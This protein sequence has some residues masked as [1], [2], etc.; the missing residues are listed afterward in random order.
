VISRLWKAVTI[1]YLLAISVVAGTGYCLWHLLNFGYFPPPM[2]YDISDTWMDWFNTAYYAVTGGAYES[3]KSIYPPVSFV[4]LRLTNLSGC[5]LGQEA[6]VARRCDWLGIGILHGFYILNIALVALTYIK[7]DRRTALPRAIALTT[8]LAMLNGLDRGNLVIVCFSF[9]VLAFGPLLARVWPKY[10]AAGLAINF[11]VYL[12]AA[13]FPHVLKRRWRFAEGA[14]LATV[15]IYILTYAIYGDGTPIAIVRNITEFADSGIS[16]NFLDLWNAGTY[17]PAESLL[18]STD[19]PIVQLIGSGQVETFLALIPI[20]LWLAQLSILGAAAATVLRPEVVPPYRLTNLG[21]CMALITSES[22]SYTNIFILF[23]VF[24]EPW[25]GAGRITA[26]LCAYALCLP[27]DII[28]HRIDPFL[29]YAF[30][31]DREVM[32]QYPITY[33][34]F[35]RPG[36]LLIIAI[37]ISWATIM[38]VWRDV[39]GQGWRLRW[40]Y[41]RDLPLLLRGGGRANGQ[42]STP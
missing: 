23:L 17:K 16:T 41:R 4:F 7:V 35:F 15:F 20:T 32:I 1:E 27:F 9:F 18:T 38:D 33:G 13:I 12:I 2:F 29:R 40:R 42:P 28:L 26:I 25:R 8:G 31:A 37:A 19:S 22:G 14:L 21:V 39:R 3:W 30:F 36:F 5:F 24:L 11:K 6:P 34:P 10:I